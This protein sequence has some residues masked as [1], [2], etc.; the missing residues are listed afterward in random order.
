MLC[1]KAALSCH[2]GIKPKTSIAVCVD[3]DGQK[4]SPFQKE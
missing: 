1:K 3:G 2:N 4:P